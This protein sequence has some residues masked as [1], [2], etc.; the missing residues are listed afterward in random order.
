[1]EVSLRHMR[2]E[3]NKSDKR[4]PERQ[5]RQDDNRTRDRTKK[6]T[7]LTARICK[8]IERQELDR[9]NDFL[10]SWG[11]ES[12]AGGGRWRRIQDGPCAVEH[13]LT[14]VKVSTCVFFFLLFLPFFSFCP[15]SAD[16]IVRDMH[17]DL[18]SAG[19]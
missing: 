9:S 7:S 8:T 14:Y 3:V 19:R 13:L 18:I 5:S 2:G 11:G 12:L 17:D 10:V 4:V 6:K 1:M 16:I 15:V